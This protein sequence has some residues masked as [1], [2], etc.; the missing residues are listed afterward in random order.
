METRLLTIDE[1]IKKHIK[2]YKFPGI[3]VGLIDEHGSQFFNHG[4][5]K[6]ESGITPTSN[7]LYEIGSM[8]KTF[9]ATLAV[10]LQNEGLLSLDDPITKFLPEFLGS[11]FDKNKITLFH[12][13]THTSGLVE[14]PL[15][16]YPKYLIKFV[17]RTS[18]GKFFP[19]RYRLDTASF[20]QVISQLKLKDNPGTKF[21]YSNSG[22]GLVG[23]IL[24][25]VTNS[26]YEKL[27]KSRILNVLSMQDTTITIS[28]NHKEKLATGYLHTG[29]QADP[30]SIPAVA[31]AGSIRSTAS[32]LLKFLKVNLG[33]EQSSLSSVFA[34]CKSTRIDPSLS[35]FNKFTMKLLMG[36]QYTEIGL[37]WIAADLKN[38]S[39]LQ[40]SGGTEGFSTIMM[41]N[42]NNKTGV[43]VLT[44]AAFKDNIKLSIELLQKLHDKENEN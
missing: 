30:I 33:L 31:S 15:R 40:H 36:A 32:D 21:R 13:I 37:G 43:V 39:I 14:V 1:I 38:F 20:L 19:T 35:F 28:E 42:P 24:E 17:F 3:S 25:R 26:T 22:V 10:Q 29:K 12:L 11:D 27:I 9:T 5:I 44:N 4:E 8:T 41:I 2:K 23:K 18:K 16:E 34:Y 7:T 6:K